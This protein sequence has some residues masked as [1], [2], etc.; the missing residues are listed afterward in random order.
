[1]TEETNKDKYI[2]CSDC[3]CKYINDEE[4]ISKDFGYTRLEEIYKTCVKCRA[5]RKVNYDTY[6]EK[7]KEYSKQYYENNKEDVIVAAK[8]FYENNKEHIQQRKTEKI[9]CNVC[10]CQVSR[11]NIS[12]HQ[13]S[14]KCKNKQRRDVSDTSDS[15][16]GCSYY[17]ESE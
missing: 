4:H 15:G 5:R 1:M 10:G 11:N 12:I 14:Q 16:S 13:Q 6:Y 9:T 2:I 7:Y 8:T 17:T 3:K